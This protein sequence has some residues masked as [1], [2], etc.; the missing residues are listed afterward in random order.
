[1]IETLTSPPG[2]AVLRALLEPLCR[3][4]VPQAPNLRTADGRVSTI[5]LSG[6]S[7]KGAPAL[8]AI[9]RGQS[10]AGAMLTPRAK[11]ALMA[12]WGPVDRVTPYDTLTLLPDRARLILDMAGS[13]EEIR[14]RHAGSGDRLGGSRSETARHSPRCW[15]ASDRSR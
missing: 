2:R 11:R 3:S 6:A 14:T 4:A 7:S 9:L 5:T 1:V 10:R 12:E 8:A 15:R 13:P